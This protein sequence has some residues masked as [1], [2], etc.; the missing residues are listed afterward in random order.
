MPWIYVLQDFFSAPVLVNDTDKPHQA[1]LLS[2]WRWIWVRLTA[3]EWCL[4][5]QLLRRS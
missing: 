2:M 4:E 1:A 5:V 3:K